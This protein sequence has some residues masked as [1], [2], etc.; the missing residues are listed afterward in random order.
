MEAHEANAQRSAF[1]FLGTVG[2]VIAGLYVAREVLLPLALATL[3]TFLLLPLVRRLETWRIPRFVAVMAV[4]T[5]TALFCSLLFLAIGSQMVSLT[6]E[7]PRYRENVLRKADDAQAR[8]RP[9]FERFTETSRFVNRLTRNMN[10]Q[11][12]GR[13]EPGQ[14]SALNQP[15]DQP[16]E[17]QVVDA[18]LPS[19]ETFRA[20]LGPLLSPV[21]T[22]SIVVVFSIFMLLEHDTLRNRFIVLSSLEDVPGATMLLD[23]AAHRVSRFLRMQL[24]VALIYGVA[25]GL[26]SL[27]AGLPNALLWGF[28]G[29]LLRFVPFVGPLIATSFPIAL[30]VATTQGWQTPLGLVLAFMALEF[31]VSNGVEPWLYGNSTGVSSM[32]VLLSALFWTWLWG[33]IGLVLA[34]PLTVFLVTLGRHLPTFAFLTTLLSDEDP[35]T[36][37]VKLYQRLLARDVHEALQLIDHAAAQGD[38]LATG[39]LLLHSLA[40]GMEDL[41][42][43]RITRQQFERLATEMRD[44]LHE[45]PAE[46]P[47]AS[48]DPDNKPL[49]VVVPAR[50]GFDD[51]AAD[52]VARTLESVSPGAVFLA[53]A[54]TVNDSAAR[55]IQSGAEIVVICATGPR[56]P[57]HTKYLLSRLATTPSMF[58]AALLIGPTD[59]DR[60]ADQPPASLPVSTTAKSLTDLCGSLR[61]TLETRQF[62]RLAARPVVTN[63]ELHT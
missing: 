59:L 35:L 24:L 40:I 7:L 32:S 37:P 14:Q 20:W 8:L 23:E 41:N 16:V 21:A 26:F 50:P 34:M 56:G 15:T 51:V 45:L 6:Q 12:G 52:V 48:T 3:L 55:V 62:Q 5:V 36:P 30:A 19:I 11:S 22:A 39:E 27:L 38:T 54:Q 43:G 44:V 53:R 1:E 4:M 42:R 29:T 13:D 18:P 47:P 49:V 60:S 61:P 25:T 2:L 17:V 58:V 31:V 9:L 46:F 33:G 10:R 63:S 28:V 57:Q